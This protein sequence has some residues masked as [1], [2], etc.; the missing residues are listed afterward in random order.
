MMPQ[1]GRKSDFETT[2]LVAPSCR[3]EAALAKVD[4][5]LKNAFCLAQNF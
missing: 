5:W 3:A 1:W 2:C 4:P